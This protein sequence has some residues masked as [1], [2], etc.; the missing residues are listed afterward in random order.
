MGGGRSVAERFEI[1]LGATFVILQ[2]A[3]RRIIE[4]DGRAP[5]EAIVEGSLQVD[6]R[7]LQIGIERRQHVQ[8]AVHSLARDDAGFGVDQQV[9]FQSF[10]VDC[11][12]AEEE[13]AWNGVDDL[14]S[15]RRRDPLQR[16]VEGIDQACMVFGFA[17]INSCLA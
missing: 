13:I 12:I 16:L 2:I 14:V 5:N 6:L 15:R 11:A 4:Q 10:D 17:A 8:R 3:V 1:D 7:A 9:R